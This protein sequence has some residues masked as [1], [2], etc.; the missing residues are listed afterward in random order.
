[1]GIISSVISKIND[2][3][4]S[5]DQSP[6]EER[7]EEKAI[8]QQLTGVAKFFVGSPIG[9]IVI[10]IIIII[11]FFFFKD[12]GGGG[13]G[14]NTPTS[15]E[16][17]GGQINAPAIPGFNV[18]I[19]A[20]DAE[21]GGFSEVTVTITH[22][23]SIAPPIENIELYDTP[24]ANL[25]FVNTT[26]ILKDTSGP[27]HVWSL[28][29]P[30]NQRSFKIIVRTDS[31]DVEIPYTI[32]TRQIAAAGSAPTASN[33]GGI[34]NPTKNPLNANFGDPACTFNR[35]DFHKKLKELDPTQADIWY[36][37][38]SCE[39]GGTYDSNAFNPVSTSGTAWGLFQMGHEAYPQYNI[40]RQMNTQYDRGDV[41]WNTQASN[42]VTYNRQIGGSFAY[43]ACSPF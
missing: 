29:E 13:G 36:Q 11:I 30:A 33:C 20:T 40:P 23:P 41:E 5:S 32:S 17:D 14:S 42:A 21:N 4:Q 22:D 26:G 18:E 6:R 19:T 15:T 37:I 43:W 31:I 24:P 12:G 9:F 39:T 38:A 7:R 28:S 8:K 1:M 27:Q 10:F 34:Y 35:N 16:Q 3:L 25:Q 2:S